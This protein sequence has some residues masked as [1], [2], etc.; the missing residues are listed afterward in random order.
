MSLSSSSVCFLEFLFRSDIT[1]VSCGM[2][3]HST[4]QVIFPNKNSTR[5]AQIKLASCSGENIGWGR[6]EAVL[7]G[8]IVLV[9]IFA[10][11][12]NYWNQLLDVQN[13]S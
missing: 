8:D 7:L 1:L 9:F 4:Q 5:I 3:H 13:T 10:S 11:I 12:L 6:T 2:R